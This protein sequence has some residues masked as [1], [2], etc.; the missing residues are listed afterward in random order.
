MAALL[1]R[2]PWQL[3]AQAVS[4]ARLHERLH[5][6]RAPTGVPARGSGDRLLHL[7]LHPENVLVSP[8]GPVVI[9]WANA[10]RGDAAPDLALTWVLLVTSGGTGGRVSARSFLRHVDR[11]EVAGALPRTGDFASPT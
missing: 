1:R 6:I 11:D 10:A 8:A 3:R 5:T 9:D 4:P 7:D 2:R